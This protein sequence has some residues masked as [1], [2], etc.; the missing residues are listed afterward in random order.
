MCIFNP[1]LRNG[2]PR[3]S[4]PTGVHHLRACA[5]TGG[6]KVCE[7]K[8]PPLTELRCEGGREG[9]LETPPPPPPTPDPS[10]LPPSTGTALPALGAEAGR[11]VCVCAYQEV[12]GG[13]M[14]GG[15]KLSTVSA[16]EVPVLCLVGPHCARTRTHTHT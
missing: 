6:E 11:C 5:R 14:T 9:G 7:V 3:S 4:E 16:T 2:T 8:F 1:P 13:V 10:L 15:M 12:R